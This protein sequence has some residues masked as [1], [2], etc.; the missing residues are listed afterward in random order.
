M[1]FFFSIVLMSSALFDNV[2]NVQNTYE[3]VCVSKLGLVVYIQDSKFVLASIYGFSSGRFLSMYLSRL[4]PIIRESLPAWLRWPPPMDTSCSGRLHLHSWHPLL[5]F[6]LQKLFQYSIL[7]LYNPFIFPLLSLSSNYEAQMKSLL[8]I[9]RIFCHVFRLGPSSPN[10]GIDMGYNGNKTPR[11]QVFKVSVCCVQLSLR[12]LFYST[13]YPICWKK[14]TGVI[15]PEEG[16][17]C[18]SLC[19]WFHVPGQMSHL[20]TIILY[21]LS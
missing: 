20:P 15:C 16:A 21:F 14:C 4:T 8:R 17:H 11:S 13:V 6:Q 1:W 18:F 2:E 12:Y 5:C 19:R 9:V 7:L 10:T 3:W